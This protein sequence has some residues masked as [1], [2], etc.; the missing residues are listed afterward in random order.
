VAD[1]IV[2]RLK[3]AA[4]VD[5]LTFANYLTGLTI[6]VYDVSFANSKA[7]TLG[8]PTPSIA[9]ATYN[10][11]TFVALP[12]P[13]PPPP[14]V[15]YPSGTTIAQHFIE[16]LAFSEVFAVEM[17]SVAT[18][19]IPYAPPAAE[20]PSVSPKPDLRIHFQR[21]GS[22]TIIDPDVY[23]DVAL[24]SAGAAPSP[25][26]YQFLPGASVSAYVTL[27]AALDPNLAAVDLPADGT[28]PNYDDLLT[29]INTVLAADPGGGQTLAALTAIQ[30]LTV[31]QC[32]N[33]ADE[34]IWGVEPPLPE[35][36]GPPDAIDSMYTNP[37]NDGTN[38]NE[39]N[40]QQF[41][42]QLN[43][44]YATRNAKVERLAKYVYALAAAV[45]CEQQTTAATRA[46]IRFPVNPV[47]TTLTTIKEAEVVL[48]GALGLDIPAE[49]FYV[50]GAL[51]PVQVTPLQRL[52]RATGAD[53]QQNL[54]QLTSAYDAGVLAVPPTAPQPPVNPAQAVR[55]LNAL[56]APV[57]SSAPECPATSA[58]AVWSDFKAYP[59]TSPPPDHWRAYKPGDDDTDFWPAEGANV[60]PAVQTA[61]LKLDL[62]AL[63]QGYVIA[64]SAPPVTLADHIA[65]HLVVHAPGGQVFSPV[66]TIAELALASASD[67]EQLFQ[68]SPLPAGSQ[69]QSDLLPTFTLPGTSDARIA[70]FV[71]YVRKFFD[72]P[73]PTSTAPN[74]LQSEP[75]ALPLPTGIDAVQSFVV[76]YE[77]LIGGSFA[78]GTPL[79]GTMVDQAVANV[80]PSDLSAQRWLKETVTTLNDLCAIANVP[81]NVNP[82]K[83]NLNFSVAEALYARG[84]TSV[85]DV[86][87]L[88]QT[89]FQ[90]ALRGT[91]AYDQAA[92]IYAKALTLGAATTPPSEPGGPFHPVNPGSLTNCIPPCY[93]SPLGPV[94]YLHELLQL[95]ERSTRDD[96]FAAPDPGHGTLGDALNG[97]RGPLG[98]LHA[99][100]ANEGTPLPL[101]DI[102][103]ECLE[104]MSATT[105]PT[106]HGVIYDTEGEMVAGHKLCE[107]DCCCH[108][109]DRDQNI[110][111]KNH[112]AECHDPAVLFSALPEH[113]TPASSTSANTNIEPAAFNALKFDFSSCCLPYSQALDVSRTY[114]RHF[115]TSRFEAMRT[116][117]RCISEFVLDPEQQPSG[118]QDHLWRYPVRI[119][120]AIEYLCIT[121]EEYVQVFGGHLPRSCSGQTTQPA[122]GSRERLSGWQLYG[123][124]GSADTEAASIRA[125]I[126]LPGFLGHTCLNYCELVDLWK[127]KFVV[128]RNGGDRESGL[129]PDCEPCC[130]DDLSIL[131]PS[132]GDVEQALDQLIVFIRLWRKLRDS[133]GKGYSFAE[134]ADICSVL[135]LFSG[136]T[137]NP[138]FIRQLAA[139]QMLRDTFNLKLVD[140]HDLPGP[141]ATGADR[142]HILSLW[143]GPAAQKW[144]WA[145]HQLLERVRHHAERRYHCAHRPE[146]LKLLRDNLDP[147]SVLVGFNP[148]IT[149]DTWHVLPTHTLRFAEVLAKI[150][151][152]NFGV[153]EILYLFTADPHLD[154]DDPFPLQPGNEA[155]DSPLGLPD[156]E[157]EFSLWSLRR[158]MLEARV[159]ADDVSEWTWP[160]I[161]RALRA[162]F[163]F[164]HADV[165]ELGE[166]FFPDVV[167]TSGHPVSPSDRRYSTSLPAAN[168]APLMWNIPP[169]GPFKYEPA[170]ETLWIRLPLADGEVIEQFAHLRALNAT[171]QR[172]VQDL[173][174]SPRRTLATFALLFENFADAE[175]HLI[176]HHEHERWTWFRQQFATCHH[177]C[178]IIAVHLSQHVQ[179][180]TGQEHPGG[181]RVALLL[182]RHLFAAENFATSSWEND[183]GHAPAVTWTPPPRGGAFAALLGLTGTG[184]LGEYTPTGGTLAWRDVS[185]PLSVFGR[186]RNAQ[187]CPVPTIVPSL[188]ATLPVDQQQFVSVLNGLVMRNNDGAWLGGAE[189][190]MV[191]W[192][193]AL[194]VEEPGVYEFCGGGPTPDGEKP[195]N[196][197]C[198]H[199]RWRVILKRGQRTW[200][201][202]KHDWH[203]EHDEEVSKLQLKRGV[204]EIAI[205]FTQRRPVIL[206]DEDARPQRTG[207]QLK[208]SGPDTGDRFLVLPHNRLFR[209]FK[210][211]TLAEG[212][213]GLAGVPA[214]F[215]SEYYSSSLRDIRCTYQ[216]L[217][218]ALLFAYRFRLSPERWAD[219]R[220]ELG[221]MLDQK[222]RFA[223]RAFYH[224]GA[225]F[226]THA[227][228]FD[229]NLLPLLDDYFAPPAATDARVQPSPQRRQALFDWWERVFDYTRVRE[230]V[231]R[232]R[233]RRLWLLFDEAEEKQPAHP[234]YLLR[235]MG[236]N[237]RH[238]SIDLHYFQDQTAPVYSV[239]SD[240]LAD[241]R[242]VI[243][244]WHADEWIQ[245]LLRYFCAKDIRS[246]RPDLWA[247][248]DPSAVVPGT[249][250]DGQPNLTGNANL[251]QFLVD[252]CIENNTPRRYEE[253]KRLNDCL[254][255][256]GRDAL[257]AYLCA[258]DRVPLP[259]GGFAQSP[260][261]LSSLLLIDVESGIC[262]RASRIEDAITAVQNFVRRARIGLE[263]EWTVTHEFAQ[264]WDQRFAIFKVWEA[265]KCRELYKENWIDWHAQEAAQKIESYRFLQSELRR[266]TLT[267]ALPGGLEYWPNQRPAIHPSLLLLQDRDVSS[268]AQLNPVRE[269]LGVLGTPERDARPSWLAPVEQPAQ[270]GGNGSVGIAR[271][272]P[273][274]ATTPVTTTGQLPFWIESAIR[275]GVRFC[276]IA[277]GGVPPASA[278]FEPRKHHAKPV[279]CS[280]CGRVHPEQVDEYYFWLL[281]ARFFKA[282]DETDSPSFF[283]FEQDDYY[284]PTT[285]DATPWHDAT[286]LPNLLEWQSSP[287][288]R[289]AWCRVHNDEFKQPRRSSAGVQVT[290]GVTADLSFVGRT[291][292]SLVFQ[293]AGGIVPTGYSGTDAPGFRYDLATDSAFV[294]PL[295][296]DPP[297][298]ASPFP[299]GLPAYPYFVYV[300]RG[301]P[302]FAKSL[303][304]EAL[305]VACALRTRCR[306]E[307]ALK[308]YA[309]AFDPL[310]RNDTWM[311]CDSPSRQDNDRRSSDGTSA[312][313]SSACCDTTDVSDAVA[314]DRSVLLHYL[315]T[316]LEWGDALMHQHSP[317]VFQQARLIFDTATMILGPQPTSVKAQ[318]PTTIQTVSAFTPMFPPINPRLLDLYCH[319][320]DRL[321]MIRHCLNT[322][323]LRDGV[324]RRDMPYWGQDACCGCHT[325]PGSCTDEC[326]CSCY[327]DE[328][329]CRLH[330]PYRFMFLL[331]KAQ[332]FAAAV[333]E[334]GAALLAA[335]EKGDAEYLA[336]LRAGHELE[337]FNLTRALRQDQWREA[338]WQRQALQ[339]SK[340]VAQTN[341]RYYAN[342]IQN[343]LNSGEQQYQDQTSTSLINHVAANREELEAEAAEIVPDL[344]LGIPSNL[345]WIPL[346][347]KFAGLFKTIARYTHAIGDIDAQTGGLDL[348]QSG[349]A[350]R[351]EEWV[352]QVEVLDIEI[353]QI[354]RQI[355]AAERHQ[356]AALQE[357]NNHQ[358]Q[359]EQSR[360]VQ[361]FLRDKFTSQELYLHLQKET[362][363]L[364]HKMY[365]LARQVAGQAERA[366]NF[367]RGDKARRFLPCE[368]WDYLHEG[369]L[370]GEHLQLALRTMEKEY[371]NLNVREYELTKHLS[372]RLHFPLQFLQLKTTG[373]CE[374]NVPE[375]MFDL[376]HPGQYMRRIKNVTLTIPCVTGPFTG[377]NCRLTL[378]SSRIRLDP[379]L[380]CPPRSCCDHCTCDNEYEP[381]CCDPRFVKHFGARE[382]IATSSGQNDSGMFELN[383]RDERYLP[384]EFLGAI[385]RWRIELP[386]ENN[387]FDMNTLS[388]VVMNLN[389]TAREGGALLRRAA[390]EVAQCHVRHSWS[391]FDVR[392]E[393]PDAWQLFRSS[394]RDR[395]G[396]RRL[397]VRLTRRMF[398]YL[399]CDRDLVITRL[400][401]LFETPEA[402]E[403]ACC[404]GEYTCC[405][406]PGHDAKPCRCGGRHQRHCEAYACGDCE[407]ACCCECIQASHAVKFTAHED[408]DEHR[409]ED[410]ECGKVEVRCVA[411]ADWPALYHGVASV[412][413]GP[414]DEARR[415]RATFEFPRKI[416]DVP[417]V[418]LLCHYEVAPLRFETPSDL[419]S[420]RPEDRG[421]HRHHGRA[422]GHH[423]DNRW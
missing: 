133:C 170:S 45:W 123:S 329:W 84:F 31:D 89:D 39:Q 178:H 405:N 252:G 302:L 140:H 75:P 344:F 88:T 365:Q 11:P 356:S 415:R 342:L 337:L 219:R 404:K 146:L 332:E 79:V 212:I 225:A 299:A 175:H 340:E 142:L 266:S 14:I 366:F 384:F 309:L 403:Q 413:L 226:A 116:F 419:R 135:Q 246:A 257:L 202:L 24:Y 86:L 17:Q 25:D 213:P 373:M 307:A 311:D 111:K 297:S 230:D 127:S 98:S 20:Y 372:L 144:D 389:Y 97:R 259:W 166:R 28:S 394:G 121:L 160:R 13:L 70:A 261:D 48:T 361:N 349:W 3:P 65:Q 9:S 81:G 316:L 134:L 324:S 350:R 10:A 46:V 145:V 319:V 184:L 363:A 58:A 138:D 306:F 23:Y 402:R 240:D 412:R 57:G 82:L 210:D 205:A 313:A 73:S 104:S 149:A 354:E 374:I 343:G 211:T 220:S 221:Y 209:L 80:F 110:E 194:L 67:W 231:E 262:E 197:G 91:V 186:S 99:T 236:A 293:V 53:Q 338:D 303:Y 36:P 288:V 19:V 400:A 395:E 295:V 421:S 317:E 320:E 336:S 292:D 62:Y 388:D 253:L 398:P 94:E 243:R 42:G 71:R 383:F 359:I 182:L 165:M 55:L 158:K 380:I 162:E 381:C 294:L 265:C 263:P 112:S 318:P 242:W 386:P 264:L 238:W 244:A 223:G 371:L 66:I 60:A 1:F 247:S 276:R 376:D 152:S 391:L 422:N 189:G 103:N 260:N 40:R 26:E 72:I 37:P 399:P 351:L 328:E 90:D 255:E 379:S 96:P 312:S 358:R 107:E 125:G 147:L 119:D 143:V 68:N 154:G 258:M 325:L 128:F 169:E 204:Y 95:S 300:A 281:D 191:T 132:D 417:R 126:P 109:G 241:D 52:K 155:L 385:S 331:Q 120:I 100:R 278:H 199:Q 208:Y 314:L 423:D 78:F 180:A 5:P 190:F 375:W 334:L 141:N 274:G 131:F 50:L 353:Q 291:A 315:E 418:F 234:G 179:A 322:R 47:A 280:E 368:P 228:D 83:P 239:T 267:V 214:D 102:V 93:L 177:R 33:I 222:T 137:I 43:S 200:L 249:G 130:L 4:P 335:F 250:P 345:S 74:F 301:A 285:Q 308:W 341:R 321:A 196:E 185:G 22:K 290:G 416:R 217:F 357:L 275:L 51:L 69:H 15:S 409:D 176:E 277:A 164:Q 34:I 420:P 183:D 101:I 117:R 298:A 105:P 414:L 203:E 272:S 106:T 150:A 224:N 139:F 327:G 198:E 364:H 148:S 114:L 54:T 195:H 187:N 38:T 156:D 283:N 151:G 347:T 378:L 157:H 206:R 8:D 77:T 287:I 129:F 360:E 245:R 201:V 254:R 124:T 56:S 49:Y 188:H 401:L 193:G 352:H 396:G 256:R 12:A 215:L 370:A 229:F 273:T 16:M 279:C 339:K 355:L 367:E 284:D 237:A 310:R 268:L 7:G 167:T 122:D 271:N 41:E 92:T 76:A 248:E 333:R 29:A 323:R 305:A 286:Q 207:F 61:L 85:A 108:D 406:E 159:T 218:K 27:P 21:A 216:L 115:C 174:F 171:E 44:Y 173:Y 348:T 181:A 87:A 235:H 153:G 296:V 233:D 382:A 161:V 282:V 397:T 172:A 369:L 326:R 377:V 330:S 32:H 30:P 304:S 192:K 168:T 118:F 270:S 393:F 18:A 64:N 63:T 362:A 227:A 232:D 269:G 407:A 411:S 136:G 59:V 251:S 2:L 410:C 289:L 346:G 113:S 163:G 408:H 390:N 35:P 392:N 6:N 387:F